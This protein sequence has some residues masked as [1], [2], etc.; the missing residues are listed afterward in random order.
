M[1][2]R[3]A[4]PGSRPEKPQFRSGLSSRL[5]EARSL[6]EQRVAQR[7]TVAGSAGPLICEPQERGHAVPRE[8]ARVQEAGCPRQERR[9]CSRR[10]ACDRLMRQP[11]PRGGGEELAGVQLR[12]P[13]TEALPVDQARA[14]AEVEDVAG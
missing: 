10:L 6:S 5:G 11:D 3:G 8:R 2:R 4:D 14:I 12:W 13:L 1:T 9:L 7:R